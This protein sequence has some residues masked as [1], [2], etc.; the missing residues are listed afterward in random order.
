MPPPLAKQAPTPQTQPRVQPQMQQPQQSYPPQGGFQQPDPRTSGQ[1][2]QAPQGAPQ[3][4]SQQM[5]SQPKPKRTGRKILIALVVL[6]LLAAGGFV[7]YTQFIDTDSDSI[8]ASLALI[9]ATYLRL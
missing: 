2:W 5:P 3:R 7:A 9:G 8:D 4:Q 6:A 1:N